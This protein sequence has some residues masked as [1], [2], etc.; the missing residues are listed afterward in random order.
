[1]ALAPRRD[2]VLGAVQVDQGLV[3]EGLLGGV[4]AQH[5]LGD[6]GVDVLDGLEHALA[7]VAVLVAVAQLDGFARAGGGAGG[8]GGAAHGAGLQQHVAFDGGVASAVQDFAADDINNCTHAYLSIWRLRDGVQTM[9]AATP[10][11]RI[12]LKNWVAPARLAR[13]ARYISPS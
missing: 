3:Q 9:G 13:A 2:L 10:S 8:H 1:M 4:Q 12:M 11:T 5:G 6:L 7:Q